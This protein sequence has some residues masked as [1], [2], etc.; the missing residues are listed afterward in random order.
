MMEQQTGVGWIAEI[1]NR[2]YQEGQ[3]YGMTRDPP[4]EEGAAQVRAHAAD[5]GERRQLAGL[6]LDRRGSLGRHAVA[7]GHHRPRR[8]S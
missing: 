5:R 2:K 1:H 3:G 7:T 8:T 4:L 6:D